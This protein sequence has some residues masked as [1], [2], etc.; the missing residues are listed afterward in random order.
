MKSFT[1]TI[2][3]NDLSGGF[4]ELTTDSGDRYQLQGADAK[5]KVEGQKVTIKGAVQSAS[6]GIGMVGSIL[7]VDSWNPQ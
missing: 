2:T 5:L 4:W 1:G 3:Q 7:K 6:M